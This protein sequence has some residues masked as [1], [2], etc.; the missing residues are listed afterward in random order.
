[1]AEPD[2]PA[3][4]AAT[5]AGQKPGALPC[6][7][8]PSFLDACG[9]VSSRYSCLK[10]RTHSRHLALSPRFLQRKRSGIKEQL[11]AELQ[12]YSQGLE[13]VPVAYD[14][15]KLIGELG[16]IYDDLGY[17]HINI[18]ADF[19]VFQPKCGQKLVGVVNKVA[20]SHI[21][22]LVHGCFNASV[23]KPMRMEVEAWQHIGVKIGDQIEFEVLRLDTD[24][25][26]VFCIR[27]R[28]DKKME[29]EALERLNEMT[30]EQNANRPET[31]QENT[32]EEPAFETAE[33]SKDGKRKSKKR[34]YKDLSPEN[35]SEV[36][37]SQ[38]KASVS[39][40]EIPKKKR[41]KQKH[42]E[43]AAE[44]VYAEVDGGHSAMEDTILE[45]SCQSVDESFKKAG[46][47]KKY[48]DSLQNTDHT[49]ERSDRSMLGLDGESLVP[50]NQYNKTKES[51]KKKRS[52]LSDPD[53]NF[54]NGITDS[55]VADNSTLE[56]I[57]VESETFL[58]TTQK[59]HKKK[60]RRSSTVPDPDLEP[61]NDD[62][63]VNEQSLSESFVVQQETPKL[64][65]HKKKRIDSTLLES[66]N[67][68]YQVEDC[69]KDNNML[70][71]DGQEF[72]E[73]KVKKKRK[74]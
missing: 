29:A 8:R 18:Q 3:D 9:L 27:G 2:T 41:K 52:H 48:Q 35:V 47:K 4:P 20:P 7:E 11:D 58:E 62:D 57:G 39:L 26:G 56:E 32:E 65:K 1:M 64:K 16:D 49:S 46:K 61:A 72:L 63:A 71:G 24:A 17:I 60:Q 69:S 70:A 15:I 42:N 30:E 53:I 43:V 67:S 33:I 51:K 44:N 34:K 50:L 40:E 19:V 23:P 13:G 22:C 74:Q 6:L 38:G 73:P 55:S 54:Q 36:V 25:V 10:V 21:G 45:S 59:K 37:E 12:R 14:N 31:P 28:L 5:E 66:D 68:G